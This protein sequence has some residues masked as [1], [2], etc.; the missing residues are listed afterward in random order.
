MYEAK[1]QLAFSI[2]YRTADPTR[3]LGHIGLDHF[4]H[5][6][7]EGFCNQVESIRCFLVLLTN[8]S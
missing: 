5:Q 6:A 3:Q 2:F 7:S 8:H 1:L 4:T